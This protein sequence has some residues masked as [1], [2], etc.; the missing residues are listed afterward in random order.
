MVVNTCVGDI[1]KKYI[2]NGSAS[3]IN[4]DSLIESERFFNDCDFLLKKTQNQ[5][6]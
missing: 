1:D 5:F 3:V 2:G 6:K 4:Y